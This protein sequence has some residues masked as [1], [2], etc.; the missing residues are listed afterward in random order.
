MLTE[1]GPRLPCS[2][3]VPGLCA[4]ELLPGGCGRREKKKRKQR[5]DPCSFWMLQVFFPAS[6][7]LPGGTDRFS[8][9]LWQVVTGAAHLPLVG[10][11]LRFWTP[12]RGCL[13]PFSLSPQ[14][15]VHPCLL[16]RAGVCVRG[17]RQSKS[18]FILPRTGF[19]V[20]ITG[21]NIYIT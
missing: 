1:G 18:Y 9:G 21:A 3:C 2:R 7:S 12:S 16:L 10:W 5:T 6:L 14:V 20:E 8:G 15:A 4:T 19:A 17:E 11:Y 13:S